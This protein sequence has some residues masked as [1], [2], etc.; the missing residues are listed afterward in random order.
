MSG[1]S[2][3]THRHTHTQ[4]HI[5]THTPESLPQMPSSARTAG[6]CCRGC[7][8][9]CESHFCTVCV[10]VRVC[11]CVCSSSSLPRQA[12]SQ[13]HRCHRTA[14]PHI[15]WAGCWGRCTG[16]R[17]VIDMHTHTHTQTPGTR[18]IRI[19]RRTGGQTDR[20]TDGKTDGQQLTRQVNTVPSRH[21]LCRALCA[22]RMPSRVK[23]AYKYL[24]E[25]NGWS[26]ECACVCVCVCARA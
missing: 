3:H 21:C 13:K 22:S 24:K 5:H 9:M 20:Q 4:T 7:V 15:Y 16:E 18:E 23:N 1:N 11:V 25:E 17:H 2:K 14:V 6:C 8:C 26:G 10:C 19:D 12:T